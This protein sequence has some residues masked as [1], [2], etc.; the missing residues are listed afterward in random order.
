MRAHK[1]WF[2]GKNGG[3]KKPHMCHECGFRVQTKWLLKE[4]VNA[5]HLNMTPYKCDQCD[6]SSAFRSYM[7][8]HKKIHQPDH[9]GRNGLL[10]DHLM[11][12]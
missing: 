1:A 7:N 8:S 6:Y 3:K 5:V 4:H 11:H 12:V 2:H 10:E 9:I